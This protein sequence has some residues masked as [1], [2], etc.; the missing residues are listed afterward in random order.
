MGKQ[1]GM[2]Q[3]SQQSHARQLGRSF[4]AEM[5]AKTKP[6]PKRPAASEWLQFF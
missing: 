6:K 2:M 4:L 1:A 5:E 3:N